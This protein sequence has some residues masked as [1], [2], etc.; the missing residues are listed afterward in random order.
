MQQD[1]QV[2]SRSKG[3]VGWAVRSS[4][5]L[6]LQVLGC[7]AVPEELRLQQEL[8]VVPALWKGRRRRKAIAMGFCAELLRNQT[9]HNRTL[10]RW[11]E[12]DVLMGD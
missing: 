2:Q 9:D 11:L 7:Q 8:I 5:H 4:A 6:E 10:E 1:H 3:A 12:Q